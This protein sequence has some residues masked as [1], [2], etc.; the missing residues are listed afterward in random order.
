MI[1]ACERILLYTS[2]ISFE[3]YIHDH[4]VQDAVLRNFE[5][6]GEASNHVPY[7]IRKTEKSIPWNS[8]YSL[9]NHIVHEY[10]DVDEEI[11]WEIVVHDL[12]RNIKDLIRI[13]ERVESGAASM[14]QA[15]AKTRRKK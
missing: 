6:L 3:D 10:F 12:P 9:R 8:M 11:L 2:E 4:L 15:P 14:S 7:N 5:V 1:G 13:L